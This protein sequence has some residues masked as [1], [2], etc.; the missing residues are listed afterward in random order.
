VGQRRTPITPEC[1]ASILQRRSASVGIPILKEDAKR[2]SSAGAI[3]IQR[4]IGD[5]DMRGG[6]NRPEYPLQREKIK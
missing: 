2:G 6:L 1:L 5:E 4:F 3:V